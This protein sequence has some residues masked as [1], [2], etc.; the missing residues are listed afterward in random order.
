MIDLYTDTILSS[1]VCPMVGHQCRSYEDFQVHDTLLTRTSF[2]SKML[3]MALAY[4]IELGEVFTQKKKS[5]LHF[6]FM[7]PAYSR[8]GIA[9]RVT[10]MEEAAR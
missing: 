2:A 10:P 4:K 3:K 8:P 7:S 9:S 6:F 1:G 5:V